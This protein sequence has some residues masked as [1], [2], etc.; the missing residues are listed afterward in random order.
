MRVFYVGL[1]IWSD[2]VKVGDDP[3]IVKWAVPIGVNVS[4]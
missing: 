1:Q 3:A 2:G 4:F